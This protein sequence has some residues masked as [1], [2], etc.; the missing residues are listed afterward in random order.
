MKQIPRIVEF[1]REFAPGYEH[2][3][4]IASAAN[5]GVRET[6]HFKG[7][8]TLTAEDIVEG[9]TFEDWI[10]TKSAFNFDIHN[11]DGA[12]LDKNGAQKHFHSKGTY[13]IPYGCCVPEKIDGLLLAGR[14][15]SGSHKAHSNY[16]AMPICC[17]IGQGCGTAAAVAVK[18]GVELRNVDV[19]K[20]QQLLLKDGVE[21]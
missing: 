14:N 8:Y 5:V 19:K 7:L 17:G 18:D 2:C 9:R 4:A 1:L 15:I 13:T 11:V 20:V 6:R 10:A 21:L 3:Y 16:R 12:G